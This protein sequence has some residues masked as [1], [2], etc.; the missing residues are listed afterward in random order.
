MAARHSILYF[1]A[2]QIGVADELRGV[3][4]RRPVVNLS[5]RSDL[6]QFPHAQQRD[7]VGHDHGLF[8]VMRDEDERDSDFALQRFQFHLH[9]AAKVGVERGERLVQQ[10]QAG[11]VYQ[12]AGQGDALLLS[13][14]DL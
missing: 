6:F 3:G 14:A 5:G 4:G 12:G 2:E 9:L 13:A 1:T 11:T 7:A 10:Q 8:L